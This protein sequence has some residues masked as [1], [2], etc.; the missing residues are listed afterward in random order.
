MAISTVSNPSIERCIEECL[1]C[2]RQ[3]SACVEGSLTHDPAAMAECIWL[4]HECVPVCGGLRN[5][6]VRELA[7]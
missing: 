3:C 4:C 7:V 5:F 1:L 2:V 6:A